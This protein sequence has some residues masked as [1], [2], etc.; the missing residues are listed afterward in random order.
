MPDRLEGVQPLLRD[1]GGG[2]GKVSCLPL[3]LLASLAPLLGHGH[4][5][6]APSLQ[7]RGEAGIV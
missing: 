6:D 3:R 5:V 4:A 1:D 2:P 7:S